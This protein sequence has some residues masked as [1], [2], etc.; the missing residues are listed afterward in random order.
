MVLKCGHSICK[1]CLTNIRKRSRGAWK[2]RYWCPLCKVS[3]R[4]ETEVALNCSLMD[5]VESMGPADRSPTI[6][7]GNAELERLCNKLKNGHPD[8][9]RKVNSYRW[10]NETAEEGYRVLQITFTRTPVSVSKSYRVQLINDASNVEVTELLE[11]GEREQCSSR[12]LRNMRNEILALLTLMKDLLSK[13]WAQNPPPGLPASGDL[14]DLP[15]YPS[16]AQL[17]SLSLKGGSPLRE[18][19]RGR[20]GPRL[21]LLNR[22][23][24]ELWKRKRRA[25]EISHA[26]SRLSKR[27]L[28]LSATLLHKVLRELVR[29]QRH[30][31]LAVAA[32][33]S[34]ESLESR[35][36][37]ARRAAGFTLNAE[38]R[39]QLDAY[40]GELIR[41][42]A[43]V[44]KYEREKT[45]R[46]AGEEQQKL[47][48][49]R[50]RLCVSPVFP[51][52]LSA[53]NPEW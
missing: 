28:R 41:L 20:D 1:D 15:G 44:E 52:A 34:R 39:A 12:K 5:V 26:F 33:A 14:R 13:W 48:R 35:L 7:L 36:E 18:G 45:Q 29:L 53:G 50:V 10:T 8:L 43:L 38:L 23:T 22:A 9:L 42:A 31:L 51:P 24:E 19:G 3:C 16:N 4:V 27:G 40:R 47:E 32:E 25:L 2:R 17:K 37:T 30:L 21:R 49:F 46:E 6:P 11:A